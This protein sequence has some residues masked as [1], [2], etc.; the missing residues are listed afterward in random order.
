[1]NES[2]TPE[3]I[4]RLLESDD[5][6]EIPKGLSIATRVGVDV[7]L[8]PRLL[9][10]VL[11]AESDEIRV[12]AETVFSESVPRE[13]MDTLRHLAEPDDNAPKRLGRILAIA[14]YSSADEIRGNPEAI[15]GADTPE[16][17]RRALEEM[18]GPAD[19]TKDLLA[20]LSQESRRS[21]RELLI[22]FFHHCSESEQ[23]LRIMQSLCMMGDE[24][25]LELV[26]SN[27]YD[28]PEF[29]ENDYLQ[30]VNA[31][32][33]SKNPISLEILLRCWHESEEWLDSALVQIACFGESAIEILINKLAEY[34]TS[35]LMNRWDGAV[36]ALAEFGDEALDRLIKALDDKRRHVAEG[37]AQALGE[38]GDSKAIEPLRSAL[39]ANLDADG[40]KNFV[41]SAGL[42]LVKL[43][44]V[45]AVKYVVDDSWKPSNEDW[46]EFYLLVEEA[47]RELG[48][49]A[50]EPLIDRLR[51][52]C[53]EGSSAVLILKNMYD[54]GSAPILAKILADKSKDPLLRGNAAKTLG[55]IGERC[56]DDAVIEPLQSIL[57]DPY[58]NENIR[59]AAKAAVKAVGHSA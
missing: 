26:S 30:I 20:Q 37:A 39:Q 27:I 3:E 41:A 4:R 51:E 17:L 9:M 55:L 40:D 32:S 5:P 18:P 11:T 48:Q 12:N 50:L 29:D 28:F 42:A 2:H 22:N 1:M 43:G 10:L 16:Q 35:E 59:D 57:A 58:E 7:S 36:W 24:P 15:F 49:D 8:L 21:L 34:E 14:L 52:P 53:N 54:Q 45:K 56:G 13:L 44:D 25:S 46:A 47:V 6:H 31:L 33:N 19:T 23:E 38:I